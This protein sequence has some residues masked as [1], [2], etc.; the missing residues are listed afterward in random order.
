MRLLLLPLPS[1]WKGMQ[2]N[3]FLGYYNTPGGITIKFVTFF[4]R[5]QVLYQ[6]TAYPSRPNG[7]KKGK[8]L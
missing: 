3:I 7:K 2:G 8:N 5:N 6:Y 4:V 1:V